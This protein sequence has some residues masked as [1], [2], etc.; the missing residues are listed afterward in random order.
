[1]SRINLIADENIPFLKGV[2]EPFADVQY[3]PGHLISREIIRDAD[4]LLIRTRT[5]CDP[6]LLDNTNVKFIG[7]A[8]IGFD[9]IDTAYCESHHIKWVN[10]PGCNS[11]SVQQYII[12]ALLNISRI[13]D[14]D[15]KHK[16]IGIVGVGNVGAK[17]ASALSALGAKV[18]LNDPPRARKEGNPGF[19]SFDEIL[20]ICDIISLHVPLKYEGEDATY[21][22]FD[23]LTFE[24]IKHGTFLF[25]TSRGE[26]VETQALKQAL[27][28]GKLAGAVLDVWEN[29]PNIDSQLLQLASIAT[30]HIAG[31]STDG[32]ANGTSQV[33]RA[34]S[35]YFNLPLLDFYPKEIPLPVFADIEI[36]CFNK[37][38]MQ[39][40]NHAVTS[41]YSIMNDQVRLLENPANFE[42]IRGNYPVRRE[43]PTYRVRLCNSTPE[44]FELL[45]KLGFNVIID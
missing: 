37:S 5:Q 15:I 1:M 29:E 42:Q 33:V 39:I 21:H 38:A 27:L 26:V 41:T 17:V 31:Y 14:F 25:N 36:D 32:K 6:S 18:K 30:P 22:L 40:I 16:T 7:T 43:F 44:I 3:F 28:T 13:R 4:V 23:N 8:T 19:V 34:L 20:A 35:A 11:S 24:K 45:T 10:A 9:H 2:L 12:A